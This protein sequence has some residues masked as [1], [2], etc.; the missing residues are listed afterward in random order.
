MNSIV[1]RIV[2]T[3]GA[4]LRIFGLDVFIERT[5]PEWGFLDFGKEDHSK[6]DS[7]FWGFGLHVIVSPLTA[8]RRVA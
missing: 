7:E 2:A 5:G 1:F 4:S 6:G 8:A 3:L